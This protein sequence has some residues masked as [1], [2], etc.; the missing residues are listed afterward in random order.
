M[1]REP[2]VVL[3]LKIPFN[4]A[5][6]IKNLASKALGAALTTSFLVIIFCLSQLHFRQSIPGLLISGLLKLL[7]LSILVYSSSYPLFWAVSKILLSE[8][9]YLSIPL[10]L[11]EIISLAYLVKKS[12]NIIPARQKSDMKNLLTTGARDLAALLLTLLLV[13]SLIGLTK[14]KNFPKPDEYL[15][16]VLKALKFSILNIMLIPKLIPLLIFPW[17]LGMFIVNYSEEES[18]MGKIVR[19][20]F[21][22]VVD[23]VALVCL[24]GVFLGVFEVQHMWNQHKKKKLTRRMVITLFLRTIVDIVLVLIALLDIICIVRAYAFISGLY[25]AEGKLIK[26]KEIGKLI[27]VSLL[28]T[29]T[30]PHN[31]LLWLFIAIPCYRLRNLHTGLFQALKASSDYYL[32][33][34]LVQ[35]EAKK[36]LIDLIHLLI[37]LICLPFIHRS[38]TALYRILLTPAH[39][40]E[41]TISLLE[42]IVLDLPTALMLAVILI[43]VVRMPLMRRRRN[44][45]QSN[46]LYYLCC[47][48]TGELLRDLL[49]LP[50]ILVNVLSPWRLYVL[51]PKLRAAP[52]PKEQRKIIKTDGI[53]PLEDYA[54]IILTVILVFSGWRT[55]EVISIV[56]THIRQILRNEQLTSSL[57]RKVFRKFLE[58]MIDVLMVAMILCIFLLLIEVYHFCRRMRT[59]YYLY[60]DRKG[61]Q[62]KKYLESIWPKKNV[63]ENQRSPVTRLNKNVF[64]NIASFLDVKSLARVSQVNK[65]FKDLA[66]FPPIWKSQYENHWKQYANVSELV[67]GDDYRELVKRGYE[68]YTKE[69]TGVILDEEER[70]YKMGARVIVLEEFVLSIFGFPHIIAL[71]AKG[72]CY[73]LAKIQLDWYFANRRYPSFGFEIKFF[74]KSIDRV[75]ADIITVRFMQELRPDPQTLKDFYHI[76]LNFVF[77]LVRIA[78]IFS[79][80]FAFAISFID[81]FALK[82]LSLWRVVP[83]NR[84]PLQPRTAN[85]SF[86]VYLLQLVSVVVLLF[87]KLLVIVLPGYL[88]KQTTSFTWLGIVF[89]PFGCFLSWYAGII[90]N[91]C[92]IVHYFP[93]FPSFNPHFIWYSLLSIGSS[94][95]DIGRIIF[96]LLK[97]GGRAFINTLKKCVSLL[98]N[99]LPHGTLFAAYKSILITAGQVLKQQGYLGDLIFTPLTLLWIFWPLLIPYFLQEYYLLIPI[100]PIEIFLI[101]K[102]YSTAKL[103][104]GSSN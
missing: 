9:P 67:N 13:C 101:I 32:F 103:A 8:Y 72:I 6:L 87:V 84:P 96:N 56:V 34:F 80:Q 45:F 51:Y 83:F 41:T 73:L 64:T 86:V 37:L 33:K 5:V 55:V 43:T 22:G 82:A 94:G 102:G 76:Q 30:F 25:T 24:V 58:L 49:I 14:M 23:I 95:V 81:F 28:D 18:G 54:T 68:N 36:Q 10:V 69:N 7:F 59:Y 74:D 66:G 38:L 61:F 48:I 1:D 78:L 12:L 98:K 53:R 19:E 40:K 65:K 75:Y 29:L 97:P 20:M 27:V 90:C 50:F 92:T 3:L 31:F 63:A 85:S 11:A 15:R 77:L 70:D 35:A 4:A 89:G 44:I 100:F 21:E 46:H 60:K 91:I 57:F 104:W 71:P 39:W 99:L 93:H 88:I 79:E 17:R 47:N 2:L 42:N 16:F 52:S 26:K 62:Y